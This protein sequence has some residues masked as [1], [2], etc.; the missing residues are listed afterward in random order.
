MLRVGALARCLPA[1]MAVVFNPRVVGDM[2]SS[3]SS[4]ELA[5]RFR[6]ERAE[7][8]LGR[9]NAPS[10][11]SHRRK[12]AVIPEIS[13]LS[14]RP[15]ALRRLAGIL[16]YLV[17]IGLIAAVIIG[18][19]FGTGFWLLVSP[20]SVTINDFSR[21]PSRVNG[22]A[23]KAGDEAVLALAGGTGTPHSAATNIIPDSALGQR[24]TAAEAAPTQQNLMQELSPSS[25]NGEPPVETALVSQ[26]VSSVAV[27]PAYPMPLTSPPV[28]AAEDDALA[29]GTKGLPA[30]DSRSAHARTVSRHSRPRSAGAHQH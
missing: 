16:F 22:N 12:P 2:S 3:L 11:I 15:D 20:A 23:L 14:R 4:I 25:P 1:T 17:S 19:F 29:A 24:P 5:R 10:L 18:V 27:S 13:T 28:V 7:P 30:R 8:D 6:T 9:G 21:D 26:P